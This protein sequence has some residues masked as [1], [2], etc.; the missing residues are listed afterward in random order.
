MKKKSCPMNQ[1]TSLFYRNWDACHLIYLWFSIP[2]IFLSYEPNKWNFPR[3]S[4]VPNR[5]LVMRI[6]QFHV[7]SPQNSCIPN[8]P[9]FT[10]QFGSLYLHGGTKGCFQLQNS[11]KLP[12]WKLPKSM[13]TSIVSFMVVCLI[14]SYIQLWKHFCRVWYQWS[15]QHL[16]SYSPM[17]VCSHV[18]QHI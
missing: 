4:C 5:P 6:E 2:I 13:S 11:L 1:V 10:R 15:R 14:R 8:R 17:G 9:L 16:P 18:I 7:K 3:Y 12:I